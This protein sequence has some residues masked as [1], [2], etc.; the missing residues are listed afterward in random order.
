MND[1][2]ENVIAAETVLSDVDGL[3][4]RLVIRGLPLEALAGQVSYEHV[5]GLLWDGFF[6]ALPRDLQRPLGAARAKVFEATKDRFG[7]AAGL[8]PF[9]AVRVLMGA[10]PDGTDL[11][12]ALAIAAAPG[13][14]LPAT[15]KLLGDR[16]WWLPSRLGWLPQVSH[17][18]GEVQ[19]ARA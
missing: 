17:G 19:P 9:D 10:L 8:A 18:E 14:L 4:G 5:L 16:N 3:A 7:A 2:L 1:G 11:E 6:P 12:A 15:M 13:V